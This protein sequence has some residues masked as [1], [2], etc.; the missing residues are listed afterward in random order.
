[1]VDPLSTDP[2]TSLSG[3]STNSLAGDP[4][5]LVPGSANALLSEIPVS[6][7]A[8]AVLEL[9]DQAV[10]QAA[11]ISSPIATA[12]AGRRGYPS[13]ESAAA[14]ESAERGRPRRGRQCDSSPHRLG[15]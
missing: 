7:E 8:A 5:A 15:A 10:T 12:A 6:V 14:F 3:S 2:V 4:L 13:L 9:V 11:A 1:M